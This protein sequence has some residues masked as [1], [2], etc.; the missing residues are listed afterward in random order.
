MNPVESNLEASYRKIQASHLLE[1][2]KRALKIE[3]SKNAGVAEGIK[4][5]EP[6][7][8]EFLRM[9]LG[10]N[11]N[12]IGLFVIREYHKQWYS[13]SY[14]LEIKFTLI[15]NFFAIH[16]NVCHGM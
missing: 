3:A 15:K 16:M 4:L 1:A 11:T 9:Y 14:C 13:S 2:E 8:D 6:I 10:N 12:P 5:E 7:T